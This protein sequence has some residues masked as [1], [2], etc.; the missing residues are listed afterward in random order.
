MHNAELDNLCPG[1]SEEP[2]EWLK[3]DL[4]M[5]YNP[6][7][8]LDEQQAEHLYPGASPASLEGT[9]NTGKVIPP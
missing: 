5:T 2:A 9:P 6:P 8:I 1:C 3:K 4:M 7:Q